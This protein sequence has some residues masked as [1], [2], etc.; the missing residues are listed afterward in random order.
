MTINEGPQGELTLRT[1]AMPAD[2]KKIAAIGVRYLI[3]MFFLGLCLTVG[4]TNWLKINKFKR[5]LI[6]GS[7]LIEVNG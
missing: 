3:M 4:R 6:I 2:N 5:L 1:L 7:A